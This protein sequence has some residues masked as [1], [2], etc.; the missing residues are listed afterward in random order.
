MLKGDDM[1]E[2]LNNIHPGE[3]LKEEFLDP[4]EITAY[5]LAKETNMPQTAISDIIKGKR[6]I[7][8]QIALRFSKFFGTTPQFWM[9][10]QDDYDLE[11]EKYRLKKELSKIHQYKIND[12]C[13]RLAVSDIKTK[14]NK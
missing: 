6:N 3:I 14:Y 5:R 10:L 9:G 4:M 13:T 7:T 8:A 12:K 2:R 11:H 1:T